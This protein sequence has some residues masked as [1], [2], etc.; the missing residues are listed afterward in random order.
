MAHWVTFP[1]AVVG[2]SLPA[3]IARAN[4][5]QQ[6]RCGEREFTIGQ[7]TH[8]LKRVLKF[9]GGPLRNFADSVPPTSLNHC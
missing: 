2:P 4:Q 3:V 6:M 1:R 9:E 8:N 7:K 5:A